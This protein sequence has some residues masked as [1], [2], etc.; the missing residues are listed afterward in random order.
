MVTAHCGWFVVYTLLVI[1]KCSE[2]Q[3][4]PTNNYIFFVEKNINQPP[5]LHS[6][7]CLFLLK[8][9]LWKNKTKNVSLWRKHFVTFLKE[10]FNKL[11]LQ[12]HWHHILSFH[13][14]YDYHVYKDLCEECI[15]IKVIK[16]QNKKREKL[17]LLVCFSIMM[18]PKFK[19]LL[20][21]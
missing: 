13:W 2:T 8:C 10:R 18:V 21:V 11:S 12:W 3:A 20:S 6:I 9:V 7:F 1:L 5:Y 15:D 16:S 17:F 14:Y 19:K 4:T